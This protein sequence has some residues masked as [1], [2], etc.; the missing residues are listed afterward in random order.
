MAPKDEGKEVGLEDNYQAQERSGVLS[1]LV[2]V[3]QS[4]N[5]ALTAHHLTSA[6]ESPAAGPDL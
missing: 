3:K 1:W 5:S 6:E 4:S 2:Y